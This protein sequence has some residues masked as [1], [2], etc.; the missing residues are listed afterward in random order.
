MTKKAELLGPSLCA[1]KT[2]ES[3][4]IQMHVQCQT[5]VTET[6][7]KEPGNLKTTTTLNYFNPPSPQPTNYDCEGRGRW[8]ERVYCFYV[9]QLYVR[10]S[11]YYVLAFSEYGVSNKH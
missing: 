3:K 8:G 2:N 7:L 1:W 6:I 4:A 11:D 10:P 9:V 5:S